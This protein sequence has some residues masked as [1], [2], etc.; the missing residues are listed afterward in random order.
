MAPRIVIITAVCMSIAG[1]VTGC[2]S[3]SKSAQPPLVSPSAKVATVGCFDNGTVRGRIKTESPLVSLFRVKIHSLRT[4]HTI[5]RELDS[6]RSPCPQNWW[7]NWG[8][9]VSLNSTNG[10]PLPGISRELSVCERRPR[11]VVNR[12]ASGLSREEGVAFLGVVSK[13]LLLPATSLSPLPRCATAERPPTFST[14]E[15]MPSGC[16]SS[17]GGNSYSRAMHAACSNCLRP[18]PIHRAGR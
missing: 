8:Y 11:T 2:G 5:V 10:L 1:A 16:R 14:D 12:S 17:A 6:L 7:G 4:I 9:T 18:L 15:P 3:S 13:P